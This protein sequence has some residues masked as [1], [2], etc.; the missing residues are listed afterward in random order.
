MRI[1]I[2]PSNPAGVGSALAAGL[3]S[4][5]HDA[6]VVTWVEGPWGYPFDRIVGT[7]ARA[8][9]FAIGAAL[10]FDVL[11]VMGGRSWLA[12]T[13]VLVARARGRTAVIQ[14]NGGDCRTSDIAHRLHPARA[15]VVD[16][17]RDR[18][19]SLHRRLGAQAARAAVVQD[20]ELVEYLRGSYARIYVAPFAIDLPAI[21]RVAAATSDAAHG[22]RLRVLHAPSNRRIKGSDAIEAAVAEAAREVEIEFETVVGSHDQ[23]LQAL[24]RADVVIDQLNAE[25]PGVLSAE[26]MAL[27]KPVLCEHVPAKL[28]SFARPCPV[29]AATPETLRE[30]LLELAGDSSRRGEL[31]LAGRRYAVEV[32]APA[33]AAEA[34]ER[35]YEH[36][37]DADPGVYEAWPGG[38]R[39][40]E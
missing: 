11:H 2:G 10:G 15:R 4:R 29:V 23:V 7:R 6:K 27:G 24:A 36:A 33:R 22:G 19:I 9:R 17:A 18:E 28:A 13:D 14:Y 5:G 16:P 34:A 31:G 20:L 12:Y 40:I 1:A 37:R 25:T 30:R 39:R 38:L 21:D 26:A 8:A 3:R 32:H 35:I